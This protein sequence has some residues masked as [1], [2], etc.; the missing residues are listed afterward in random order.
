MIRKFTNLKIKGFFAGDKNFAFNDNHEL[1]YSTLDM[2]YYEETGNITEKVEKYDPSGK[3]LAELCLSEMYKDLSRFYENLEKQPVE[4]EAIK[5]LFCINN[6]LVIST[7]NNRNYIFENDTLK[8]I[9]GH[10]GLE[11]D[12]NPAKGKDIVAQTKNFASHFFK[13]NNNKLYF[14]TSGSDFGRTNERSR[15]IVGVSNSVVDYFKK[16]PFN[17][18][19]CIDLWDETDKIPPLNMKVENYKNGM[20]ER[21]IELTFPMIFQVVDLDDNYFL[22]SIFTDNQSKAASANKNTPYYFFKVEKATGNIS[23]NIAPKD[24]SVYKNGAHYMM[25]HDIKNKLLQFK[26]NDYLHLIKYSGISQESID[27][28]NAKLSKLRNLI[29][30]DKID[31]ITYFFNEAKSEIV[32]FELGNTKDEIISNYKLYSKSI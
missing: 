26:T 12:L 13:S 4:F 8:Y 28:K 20:L 2:E 31:N 7:V 10:N 5:G 18:T 9:Y 1:Y 27:L 22:T 14:K 11:E 17:S 19:Y 6:Q 30:L 3:F 24:M 21:S 23:K 32:G 15:Y 29:V 25:I 16:E